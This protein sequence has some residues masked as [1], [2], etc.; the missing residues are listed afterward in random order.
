MKGFGWLDSG[1]KN[2]RRQ[3]VFSFLYIYSEPL[4]KLLDARFTFSPLDHLPPPNSRY[5]T[6]AY[7]A[8]FAMFSHAHINLSPVRKAFVKFA[9]WRIMTV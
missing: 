2:M 3:T 4:S 7:S 6:R 1:S 5:S 8:M 9:V